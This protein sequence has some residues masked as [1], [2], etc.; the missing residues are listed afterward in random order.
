MM[1][2]MSNLDNFNQ[3]NSICQIHHSESWNTNDSTNHSRI[4]NGQNVVN[5]Q[6]ID[7]EVVT[8]KDHEQV[9]DYSIASSST[10]L[11]SANITMRERI[12]LHNQISWDEAAKQD[13][14]IVHCRETTGELHKQ[15]L[16]SG[17]RGK[18][19]KVG[20]MWFTPT[21]FES[22]AGR[23]SS[24]D[25]KRS[26]RF[27]GHM[28]QKLIEDGNLAPHAI[29]CT[30][31]G[32]TGDTNAPYGPIRL[33]TPHRR[34]R[35]ENELNNSLVTESKISHIRNFGNN[36][37]D[38]QSVYVMSSNQNNCNGHSTTVIQHDSTMNTN[39]WNQIEELTNALISNA[40]QIKYLVEQIKLHPECM[41]QSS[42]NS[43]AKQ[44]TETLNVL[45]RAINDVR[46]DRDTIINQIFSQL[47]PEISLKVCSNCARE[48]SLECTICRRTFYCSPYCQ[49]K[50]WTNHLNHCINNSNKN[51]E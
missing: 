4:E 28:L 9:F 36:S 8:S 17:S 48:A 16:G 24:K 49:Q 6:N 26:I 42:Q 11:S 22:M 34:K 39:I 1:E 31:G 5:F 37:M 21:E 35:N 51:I 45:K 33:F 3:N 18:C 29:S 2:E 19:I 25:W 40:Q 27:G 44:K 50:D 46:S 20:D 47:R 41:D 23:G 38:S 10:D 13:I 43:N 30:C 15:K 14:L 12:H 7:S 32:C